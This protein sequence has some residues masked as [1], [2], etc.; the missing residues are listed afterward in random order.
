MISKCTYTPLT[1]RGTARVTLAAFSRSVSAG[2]QHPLQA[3]RAEP[4]CHLRPQRGVSFYG[5]D[6]GGV[7]ASV[8]VK[9]ASGAGPPLAGGSPLRCLPCAAAGAGG[10]G[11]AAQPRS[12]RGQPISAG[13]GAQPL[14]LGSAPAA[15]R[16]SGAG[17][18]GSSGAS[19]GVGSAAPPPARASASAAGSGHVGGG[20]R[21]RR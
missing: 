4:R 2:L 19:P 8:A 9:S 11:G 16:R 10:E 14:P 12:R 20:E 13:P 18:G 7:S 1:T 17:T 5:C 15:G 6:R 3:H 21:C